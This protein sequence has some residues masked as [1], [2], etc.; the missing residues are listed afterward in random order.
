MMT[1]FSGR[2]V[3]VGPYSVE[4]SP[5]DAAGA[6]FALE[7]HVP[8]YLAERLAGEVGRSVQF[9]TRL[10]LESVNQGASFVPRLLGFQSVAE[11][12][13]FE[14][15]TTVKGLGAR[16]V[17]RAMAIEPGQ[18]A[19][20]IARRDAKALT[21]LPEIGKRLAE[22]IIAEL[23]GKVDDPGLEDGAGGAG[24]AGRAAAGTAGTALPGAAGEAVAALVSLGQTTAEATA[25]VQRAM[26]SRAEGSPDLGVEDVLRMVFSGSAAGG[27]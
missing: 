27:L 4:V 22:T 6:A 21:Q 23:H 15:L 5:G 8:A 12:A 7:V 18:I 13:L 11:R 1:R 9:Y 19:A 14:K 3:G 2:V 17:L 24:P 25:A 10:H 20:A 16:R 26:A